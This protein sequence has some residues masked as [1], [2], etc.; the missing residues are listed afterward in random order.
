MRISFGYAE[1][2]YR[3]VITESTLINI[4]SEDYE[5]C[6]SQSPYPISHFERGQWM[7]LICETNSLAWISITPLN[8][9]CMK[10]LFGLYV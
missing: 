9:Q 7:Y 3:F 4:D 1:T 6:R 2:L 8:I 10:P 5:D